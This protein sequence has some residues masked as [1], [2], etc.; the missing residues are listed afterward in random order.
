MGMSK[1]KREAGAHYCHVFIPSYHRPHSL[2]TVNYLKK[3]GWDMERVVVFVDDEADDVEEYREVARLE[4]FTLHVFEMEEARKRY[5]YVHR[6]SVSRRSAGQAGNTFQDY[7]RERGI[8]FYCV[9]D[10]DTVYFGNFITRRHLRNTGLVWKCFTMMEELMRRRHIGVMGY[11]QTGDF[12]GGYKEQLFMRKVMNTTFYLLPYIYRGERGVQ[13][14]DTSLFTGIM[15]E[16]LFSGTAVHAIALKQLQSATQ[17]GG[18]T[19]LYNECKLLNKALVTPIQFPSAI[20]GEKQV[21]NG[22]R[23]HHR[24]VYKYL[25]PVVIKGDPERDNI[26]WD[27]WEEDYPFTNENKIYDHKKE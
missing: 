19:D 6:A 24:I 2:R 1:S 15:N 23:L 17:A 9:M 11:P 14:D 18:L 20:F 5:D 25:G 27:K 16:G 12:I 21:M 22:G 8:D 26:A 10:D 13:D 3:I 4:G 7:A